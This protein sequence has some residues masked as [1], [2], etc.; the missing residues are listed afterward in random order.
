[1]KLSEIK[2]YVINLEKRED[3]LEQISEMLDGYN[4]ERIDAVNDVKGY[5]GCVKSHI[6]S[7]EQARDRGL[8]EVIIME[9]DHMFINEQDFKYPEECDVCL[10]TG[11]NIQG[12]NIN[13]DFIKITSARHTDC[14]LVKQHYYDTMIKC[15]KESL[16]KL[17]ESYTLSFYLDI[18]WDKYMKLDQFICLRR[19]T[20]Y[21]REGYSDIQNQRQNREVKLII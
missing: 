13:D 8:S 12:T 1:M 17:I 3:R 18:Y 9:D 6:K 19:L 15:F 11:K 10:L 16:E 4:W 20:G 5:F 2:I 14:Y 21:Q 7:L